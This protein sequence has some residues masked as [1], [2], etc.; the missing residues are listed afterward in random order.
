LRAAQVAEA[1]MESDA[2]GQRAKVA[3]EP[4]NAGSREGR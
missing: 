4:L 1:I 3:A 2:T